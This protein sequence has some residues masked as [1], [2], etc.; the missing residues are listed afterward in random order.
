MWNAAE[1]PNPDPNV[2]A[3]LFNNFGSYTIMATD[4]IIEVAEEQKITISLAKNETKYLLVS[5]TPFL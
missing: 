1:K 3:P 4:N 2:V 5:I